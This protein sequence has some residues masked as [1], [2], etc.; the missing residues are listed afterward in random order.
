MIKNI[1]LSN[2]TENVVKLEMIARSKRLKLIKE[3]IP[4]LKGLLVIDRIA[5]PNCMTL[6]NPLC[7]LVPV[8]TRSMKFGTKRFTVLEPLCPVCGAFI[9][10]EQFL[11]IEN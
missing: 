2:I 5:C 10:A 1:E 7:E 3:L 9:E 6:V 8:H 4:S 11:H